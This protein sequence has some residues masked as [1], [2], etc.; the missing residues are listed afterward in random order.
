MV[1]YTAEIGHYSRLV[2]GMERVGLCPKRQLPC[3]HARSA[4][5]HGRVVVLS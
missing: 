4:A 5:S 1:T 2:D 3:K